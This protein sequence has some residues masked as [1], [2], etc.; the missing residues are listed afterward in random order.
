MLFIVEKGIRGGICHS[1]YWYV[2]A[3]NK[4]IKYCDKNKKLSYIQYWNEHN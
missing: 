3:I 4:Y 1:I 2:K